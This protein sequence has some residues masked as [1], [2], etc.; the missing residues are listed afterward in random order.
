MATMRP[1]RLLD[2]L[3]LVLVLAVA[4]G[5]R[6]GYLSTCA[7]SGRGGGP[8]RVQE[9]PSEAFTADA[10]IKNVRENL[11]FQGK[12]PFAS[13]EE[14]TAHLSPGYSYLVGLLGQQV[15][16]D[17][18]A[19][20]VRWTQVGLGSLTAAFYFLF[21]RRAFR[22]LLVGTLA[23]IFTAVHPFW[24]IDVATPSDATLSGTAL[25]FSLFLASQAGEK[26]GALKSLLLGIS[27]AGLALVRAAFLPF[28]FVLLCWFLMR[29]RTLRLGWLCA[30]CAFLGFATALAPWTI[31]NYQVFDEPV[32]VVSTTYLHLWIGNNPHATGGPD[33]EEMWTSAPT[34]QLQQISGQPARYARLGREVVDEISKRPIETVQRR[35]QA[36]LAFFLGERWLVEGAV[37][38]EVPI[39]EDEH[40]G[41]PDWLK[42]SYSGALNGVLLG[43][44]F[45]TFLGWRWSYGW[46]W[47]SIPAALAMMWVPLPYIL[48]HA[49]SL[50]SAR[51]PLDGVLLCFSAFALC[52][53]LPGLGGYLLGGAESATTK[54]GE[55]DESMA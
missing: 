38:D 25:A 32:P 50:S 7:D 43:M 20:I 35:L 5:A 12:A 42:Q 45:L 11:S 28:S 23:G 33:T 41:M 36:A 48:G 4:A 9:S 2:L 3:L 10:L 17:R 46:R 16:E 24:V 22:S 26:G 13:D 37:A 6:A 40:G 54:T 31:R 15:G 27:L 52:C 30:L 21:A 18:V 47:E 34:D 53:F 44:V 14:P 55:H 1:F 39:K 8:L 51:L 19:Y 29:S 49:G